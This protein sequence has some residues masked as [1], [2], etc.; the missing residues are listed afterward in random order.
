MMAENEHDDFYVQQKVPLHD[1][2]TVHNTHKIEFGNFELF[3]DKIRN[4]CLIFC[5]KRSLVETGKET[6]M[7]VIDYLG[8]LNNSKKR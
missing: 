8:T 2:F 3:T 5:K 6:W 7:I 4:K 1:M